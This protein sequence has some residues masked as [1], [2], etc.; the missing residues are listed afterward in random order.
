M[1]NKKAKGKGNNPIVWCFSKKYSEQVDNHYEFEE[2]G[3]ESIAGKFRVEVSPRDVYLEPAGIFNIFPKG[4]EDLLKRKKILLEGGTRTQLQDTTHRQI[5]IYQPLD[6]KDIPLGLQGTVI[7][8]ALIQSMI[9]RNY[10]LTVAEIVS[11]QHADLDTQVEIAVT[12]YTN[13]VLRNK[14]REEAKSI[15]QQN[16]PVRTETVTNTQNEPAKS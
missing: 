4:R 10:G 2:F 11:K 13:E 9:L 3:G 16:N 6:E 1:S 15:L 5:I 8:D 12:G 14:I 7:G